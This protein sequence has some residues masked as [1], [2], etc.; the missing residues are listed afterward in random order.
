MSAPTLAPRDLFADM[1][2]TERLR[3][4]ELEA[5]KRSGQIAAWWYE[6]WTF[7]LADD[8]RYTPDFVIQAN[9]G[10][11]RVEEIKGFWRDDARVKL[12]L[13]VEQ[14]GFPTNALTRSKSG[15][16]DVETFA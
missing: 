9:D 6:R 3:A 4:V 14:F 1:N 11:L 10:A 2:K 16:W 12:R 13:F 8:C 7:K 15:G 5:M